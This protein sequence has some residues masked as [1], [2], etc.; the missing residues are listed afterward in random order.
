MNENVIV[1]AHAVMDVRRPEGNF[2]E[3]SVLAF[4]HWVQGSNSANRS[5][6]EAFL[7]AEPSC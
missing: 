5:V 7:F 2:W 1:G 3:E 4:H 6:Q